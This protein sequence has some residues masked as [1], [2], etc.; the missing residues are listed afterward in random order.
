MKVFIVFC[1][2]AWETNA[3]A[4]VNLNEMS[5][6]KYCG[7]W[8]VFQF[9]TSMSLLRHGCHR[10]SFFFKFPDWQSNVHF[11]WPNELTIC[12]DINGFQIPA[13]LC[14][15]HIDEVKQM[16]SFF[17]VQGKSSWYC[18]MVFCSFV[19]C[20]LCPVNKIN[21]PTPIT[22]ILSSYLFH[23]FIVNVK[24]RMDWS[25]RKPYVCLSLNFWKQYSSYNTCLTSVN[26]Q[27]P[28]S[29]FFERVY[30]SL[31]YTEIPW[32][33]KLSLTGKRINFPGMVTHVTH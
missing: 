14:V 16:T 30:F 22:A 18:V 21:A 5:T 9:S 25:L 10:N 31:T 4:R 17:S 3:H 6:Y 27:E 11:P 15:L 33:V 1:V 32:L 13:K 19:L 24:C 29:N 28:P 26:K 23:E 2:H 8:S 12:P 20:H 7:R